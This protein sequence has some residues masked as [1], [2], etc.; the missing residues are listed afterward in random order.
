MAAGSATSPED[1]VCAREDARTVYALLALERACP[2][3]WCMLEEQI[4]ADPTLSRGEIRLLQG[5]PPEGCP[6]ADLAHD[7]GIDP[8]QLSPMLSRLIRRRLLLRLPANGDGRKRPVVIT[9]RGR[10]AL[11]AVDRAARDVAA[12]LLGALSAAERR[13][14]GEAALMIHNT[15]AA[16][17]P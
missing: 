13:R 4:G 11:A 5:I 9:G 8:G 17:D 3:L 6:A 15:L 1:S 14:L 2:R 10:A 7:L 12:R 16:Y